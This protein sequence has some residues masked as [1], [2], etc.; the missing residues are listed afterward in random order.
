M[1]IR[2]TNILH[3]FLFMTHNIV[4]FYSVLFCLGG[5]NGNFQGSISRVEMYNY[6]LNA[7]DIINVLKNVDLAKPPIIPW[8][9]YEIVGVQYVNPSEVCFGT[10]TGPGTVITYYF[11]YFHLIQ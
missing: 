2:L 9:F 3:S 8:D 10:C 1:P 11:F 7:Q 4:C 5:E 6:V